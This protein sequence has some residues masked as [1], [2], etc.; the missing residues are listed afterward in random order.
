MFEKKNNLFKNP[1]VGTWIPGTKNKGM[2]N[3]E[4]NYLSWPKVFG[5]GVKFPIKIHF[6]RIYVETDGVMHVGELSEDCIIWK[7]NGIWLR[8]TSKGDMPKIVGICFFI[9]DHFLRNHFWY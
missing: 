5:E 2:V 7:N 3:I 6:G 9:F 1:F 4:E 8:F